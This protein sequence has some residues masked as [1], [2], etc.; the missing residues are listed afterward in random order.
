M[1][2]FYTDAGTPH[3]AA[4]EKSRH[5]RQ[6]RCYR[7]VAGKKLVHNKRTLQRLEIAQMVNVSR[8]N[9]NLFVVFESVYT[10]RGITKAGD[11]LKLTQPAVS[12]SLGRLRELVNDPLFVRQGNVMT[13]TP[14]AHE[15]IGP[16]RRA[17]RE[18]EDSLN[19][20][21]EFD[22]QTSRREFKIGM[23]HLIEPAAI[24]NLMGRIQ[25]A[26]AHV[27][28]SSVHHNRADF[29]MQL[30]MGALAAAVDVLLPLTH[31]IHHQFLTGGPMVVVARREHPA[32]KG[33]MTLAAY[34]EQDHILVSSRKIG[35]ALED[36]E[37]AR[38]GFERRVKLRCQHYWTACKVASDSD[39]ILTMPERYARANNE[40]FGN[41]VIPFPME[42]RA[43][44]LFL[45]WH[46]SAEN[47][48]ANRW[49]REQVI[50]SFQQT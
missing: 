50:A 26:A 28:I 6:Q 36:F 42:V 4:P 7:G 41:Q 15:L 25:D 11:A 22:P 16:V 45:Y 35:Q 32:I 12:H 17:L 47:D 9:L 46:A 30:I 34:L 33:E 1:H 27:K 20:L 23:R 43:P 39:L 37:L 48:P 21:S 13:P 2:F 10:E 29:Q 3:A 38:L 5:R 44:D 19:Q 14:L 49:L 40:P 31:D 8:I 24:P 18:I